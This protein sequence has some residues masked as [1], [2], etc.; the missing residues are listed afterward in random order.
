[1]VPGEISFDG[2]DGVFADGEQVVFAEWVDVVGVAGDFQLSDD[3]RIGGVG[4]V[5]SEQ[6]VDLFEGYEES[7]VADEP[8]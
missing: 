3:E 2:F 5:E 4:E 7:A 6:R 1:M 8:G